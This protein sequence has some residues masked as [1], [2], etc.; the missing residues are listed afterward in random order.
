MKRFLLSCIV[1]LMLPAAAGAQGRGKL[2]GR[3]L[4][5]ETKEPLMGANVMVSGTTMGAA[6]GTDGTFVILNVPPGRYVLTAS[7][8]GYRKLEVQGVQVNI[9]LTTSV[10][11]PM[12]L[13]A[14]E[15]N[16]VVVEAKTPTIVKDRTETFSSLNG[17]DIEKAPVE[18][19]RQALE[20]SA[21]VQRT[22]SGN[23]TIRGSGSYEVNVMIDGV[24]QG[25]S[26]TGVPGFAAGL[27]E[28]ANNTWKYDFNPLGVQQMQLISGGFSAEYGNAQAGIVKIVSKEGGERLKGEIRVEYRPPGQYHWGDYIYSENAFEW[29]KWGTLDGWKRNLDSASIVSV[30]Q[31]PPDSVDIWRQ[32]MYSRWVINHSPG[33][34][35]QLGAYDY[36]KLA[37]QRLM[38][39]VGGPLG[40]D[41][42]LVRFYLSGERRA[43][44]TRMPTTEKVQNYE[45]YTLTLS[46]QPLRMQKM[47]LTMMYQHYRGGIYS[48]SE[49]I[50][51][52][53]RD[54]SY[55]YYL[56]TDVARDEYTNSQSLTWTYT[57]SQDAFSEVRLTHQFENN[58]I[59][60]EPVPQRATTW[61]DNVYRGIWYMFQGPWDESYRTIYSFTTFNQQDLRTHLYSLDANF[62]LQITPKYQLKG[63]FQGSYWDLLNSAVYSSFAANAFI[64][65]TGFA[66]YYHAYPYYIAGYLQNK[67]EYEGM[68]ANIGMRVDLYNFN[69]DIPVDRFDSI[70]Y[71]E[72]GNYVGDPLTT[73]PKTFARFSPRLG[74]SFP[75]GEATAFRLQYGHF[76]S[77]PLF[78]QAY[79]RTNYSGW[80]SYGNA[81]LAP[82]KTVNYEIGI[83]QSLGG[84]HR[85]DFV[86]Y[87][88]DRVSQ[89]GTLQ[90]WKARTAST[91]NQY[92]STY[93]N[94]GFGAT[95]G[96]D[97]TLERV[98]V[99]EW[100]YRLTY[101]FS[102][103][104]FGNYG[105]PRMYSEDP[106]D[107]R[108]LSDPFAPTE[109]LDYGD[110][111]HSFRAL[112][113]YSIRD[114]EGPELLGMRP[115]ENMTFSSTYA[116]QSG[117][118]Y[119]Y[120][121]SYDQS[122][123]A[124]SKGQVVNNR[125]YPLEAKMDLNVTKS[126]RLG[127]V[128]MIVGIRINNL[129]DNRWLT[130]ALNN[131]MLLDWVERNVTID[132]P[133]DNPTRDDY[134]Y[135]S[136]Q[137]Y[138]N[139]PRETYLTVGFGF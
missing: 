132:M 139:M 113:S 116:A 64:T 119:T 12:P 121:P 52:A 92:Y 55:K 137:A 103:T 110:R 106:S 59:I 37:Y 33:S 73:R 77:M 62:T 76:V 126:L 35:N 70:Y 22:S 87:Y 120:V 48:G 115:F 21:S 8:L 51:W 69:A 42:D 102:R 39:G 89:I 129:F 123:Y 54:A 9:D 65:R 17:Q 41:P 29:K 125:R 127:A 128:S 95:R 131:N 28:K 90:I 20:L 44:P 25:T 61:R 18:G 101:S 78:S 74:L 82:K 117:T 66:E 83:Q 4:D 114:H 96:F 109:F 118:P 91:V 67:L 71:A 100:N 47:K 105:S 88:N 19:L 133:G 135:R 13:A 50:R 14:I 1:V 53:G 72:G 30:F 6:S 104:S 10:D 24:S 63:G 31:V 43:S 111:T 107:P 56:V 84:T 11:F 46:S 112:V 16:A 81:N 40:S 38:F 23:I 57:V 85:L 68:V 97:V 134:R 122:W 58:L 136:F 80:A 98:D 27:G 45:N 93:D 34:D 86:A 60:L 32:L 7:M 124:Y 79:T 130:P 2:A 15:M 5:A 99:R 75:V 108:N 36:R 3:V 138:R 94:N 26:S 49:D